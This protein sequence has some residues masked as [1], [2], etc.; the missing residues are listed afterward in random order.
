MFDI[1]ADIDGKALA[2]GPFDRGTIDDR[3]IFIEVVLLHNLFEHQFPYPAP[4]ED[5][6]F[7]KN[8]IFAADRVDALRH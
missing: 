1:Q 3:P 5:R 4:A 8:P 6:P 2:A 7:S